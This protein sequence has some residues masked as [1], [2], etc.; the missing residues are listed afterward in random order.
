[1]GNPLAGKRLKDAL[2]TSLA[3]A[4]DVACETDV[5]QCWDLLSEEPPLWS[6]VCKNILLQLPSSAASER[7]FSLFESNFTH[8]QERGLENYIEADIRPQY[9]EK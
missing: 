6:K 1:M 8:R 2:S 9:N 7:V 5:L 3:H 4:D